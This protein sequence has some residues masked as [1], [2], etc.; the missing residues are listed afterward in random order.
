MTRVLVTGGAGILGAAVVR[1][2]LRDPDYEVRVSDQRAAPG[3]MREGCEVHRG[4]LRVLSEARKAFAGCSLVN[5]LAAIVEG[6][7]NPHTL[8]EA[9]NALSNAVFRAALDE[10]VARFVYVSSSTVYERATVFPT[11]EDH[12]EACP[13]PRSAYGFSNL[14]GETYCRAAHAE[15]GLPFTICRPFNAYGP[16]G[17]DR[18][19][20][21]DLIRKSLAGDTPLTIYGSGEQTRTFTHLDDVADGVVCA[22]ATPAAA[23]EAVNIAWREETSIAELARICWAACD[24]DPAALELASEPS[25]K[26][27]DP[28]RRFAS[29]EKA[30]DLLGWEA[31]IGVPEGVARTV[32]WLRGAEVAA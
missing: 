4:D 7:G 31:R 18:A 17:P 29:V 12:T 27:V 6:H 28:E 19:V 10:D 5:H 11:P 14:T 8:T 1:R 16:G 22:M 20:I 32:E 24:H 15:H 21:P 23:G 26:E 9:N 2:L 3:W 25:P 13:P 30:R